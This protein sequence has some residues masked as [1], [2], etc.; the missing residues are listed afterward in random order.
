MHNVKLVS[1]FAPPL[2]HLNAAPFGEG[3]PI[4]LPWGRGHD[5]LWQPLFQRKCQTVLVRSLASS[6]AQ[7]LQFLCTRIK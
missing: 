4:R 1:N 3:S 2:V 5:F 6:K 7:W